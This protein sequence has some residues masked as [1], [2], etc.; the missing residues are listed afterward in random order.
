MSDA[1]DGHPTDPA[2]EVRATALRRLVQDYAEREQL[3]VRFHPQAWR[4]ALDG[5]RLP[6]GVLGVLEES[7]TTWASTDVR[8]R[9]DRLTDRAALGEVADAALPDDEPSLLRTFLLVQVWGAG[10]SGTPMLRHT[11]AALDDRSRLVRSL[12]TTTRMLREADEEVSL[13]AAYAAW[14]CNGVGRSFLT[15]NLAV[16]G[17]R[18]GRPWQPLILDDRVLTTLNRSLEVTTLHLAASRRWADRY[19][20]YVTATH[21]WA[22]ELGVSAERLEWMLFRHNGRPLAASGARRRQRRQ[23]RQPEAIAARTP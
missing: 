5:V 14:R 18:E 21:A 9:G 8:F 1:P 7:G 20:A 23:P 2:S 11:R 19:R 16:L 10:T 12:A 22:R 17:R 15:R 6:A 4:A 3:P 13:A